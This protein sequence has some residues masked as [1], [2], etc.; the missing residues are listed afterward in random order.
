MEGYINL[1]YFNNMQEREANFSM[2]KRLLVAAGAAVLTLGMRMTTMAADVPTDYEAWFTFDETTDDATQVGQGA[3]T[4]AGTAV[5]TEKTFNY[6]D[7]KDGKAIAINDGET[8][9]NIGLDTNV[10]LN[11]TDSFTITFWAKAYE[12]KFASPLVWVGAADQS[13]E[14]WIGLWAG[15]NAGTW[16]DT[17][18]IGSN[19]ATGA[20]VGATKALSE[21]GEFGYDYITM[22]VDATTHEGVLYYNGTEVARTEAELAALTDGAHVYVGA[23]AWDAPSHMEMDNLVIYKRVLSADEVAALYGVNGVPDADAEEVEQEETEA[24]EAVTFKPSLTTPGLDEETTAA[25]TTEEDSSSTTII[26]VVVVVVLVVAVVAGVLVAT[27]KK[28][29]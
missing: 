24:N 14:A 4:T 22:T 25:A 27:K 29:A 5:E 2:K 20:R 8:Q 7:G 19:D 23:N 17:V 3:N 12:A 26:I 1:S 16:G 11:S 18:G 13:T 15:F 28:K 10:V 6:V 9:D 21:T